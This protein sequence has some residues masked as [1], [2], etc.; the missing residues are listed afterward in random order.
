[1]VVLLVEREVLGQIPDPAA[2]QRDL[3]LGRPRILL[4]QAVVADDFTLL[5]GFL[6]HDRSPP[7][8]GDALRGNLA[9]ALRSVKPILAR[10]GHARPARRP[11]RPR[12]PSR[13]VPRA[14]R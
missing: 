12:D 7:L 4:V 1:M 10:G 9:Q 5:Q 14:P 8:T 3:H 13:V 11:P 2:E 6:R